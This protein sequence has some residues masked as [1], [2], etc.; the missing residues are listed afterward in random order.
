LDLFFLPLHFCEFNFKKTKG[1]Y[2]IIRIL[3]L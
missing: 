3:G 2:L 1:P